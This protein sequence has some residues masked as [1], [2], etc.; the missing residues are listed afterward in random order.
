MVP[1]PPALVALVAAA[2]AAL[3]C[4]WMSGWVMALSVAPAAEHDAG[5]LRPL[6]RRSG[7]GATAPRHRPALPRVEE[8]RHDEPRA[9]APVSQPAPAAEPATSPGPASPPSPPARK[10]RTAGSRAPTLYP[11]DGPTAQ[12]TPPARQHRLAS[13]ELHPTQPSAPPS[14]VRPRRQ[15]QTAHTRRSH[16]IPQHT[17]ACHRSPDDTPTTRAPVTADTTPNRRGDWQ[18][19]SGVGG[20]AFPLSATMNANPPHGDAFRTISQCGLIHG[21]PIQDFLDLAG[22]RGTPPRAQTSRT[23]VVAAWGAAARQH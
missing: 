10:R 3:M 7:L 6:H 13:Q 12:P 20:C 15:P 18:A 16:H 8:L 4:W 17:S 22:A 21:W 5:Q 14:R 11:G 1:A 19:G 2:S 9:R 23:R